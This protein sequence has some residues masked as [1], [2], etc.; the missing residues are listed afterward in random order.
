MTAMIRGLL[1]FVLVCALSGKALA[2]EGVVEKPEWAVHFN[3]AGVT[4]TIVVVD[5]RKAPADTLVFDRKRAAQ[6]FAPASTYKI[7]HTLYALDA[8]AVADEFQ[9]FPWDG[10]KRTFAGHNQ[11]QNLRSAMRNSTLWVYQGFSRHIGEGRARTYLQKSEYGNADP[12]AAHGD[13]WVDGNLRI[14]AMEQVVFLQKLYR[15]A[16]PFRVEHQRLVK[17]LMVKQ[18][19]SDWLLRG[20]TGW[21]GSY[22]WWVGWVETPEGAVF[23][24]LNIDTP[25]RLEDLPKRERIARAVLQTMGLLESE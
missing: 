9:V 19:T 17:D 18:A 22:G 1:A 7:P 21:E 23:F 14:S 16:L 2:G 8:G 10:V 4:G 15:N 6:R 13:Y 20:K 12:T 25:R 5:E 3:K 24:V 11:D